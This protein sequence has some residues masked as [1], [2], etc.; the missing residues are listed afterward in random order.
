MGGTPQTPGRSVQTAE[1]CRPEDQMQKMQI[2]QIQ[3]SLPWLSGRCRWGPTITRKLEAIKKLLAPTNVNELCQFLCITGF[4]RKFVPFYAN[5]TN[6]LT[7]L[8]RKGTKFMWSEQCNNAFNILKEELSKL[9]S[10]QF[11]DPN[12]PFKLLT[13]TSNCSYSGILHQAQDEESA[14]LILIAYFSGSCN[15]T[16]QPWNITQ[17]NDVLC[18]GSINKFSFYLTGAEYTLYCD[19]K[20]L[21]PFLTTGLKNKTM[22]RWALQLQQY[23][24]KFQHVAGKD[25]HSRCDI[26]FENN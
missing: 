24:I 13:D 7:K 23:N 25:N 17:K 14:Q 10:L 3:S 9:L 21:T 16:Q 22:D 8:V 18:I 19:H 2:F 26:T 15:H 6:C 11:P 1:A 12:K 4:Y 5:I 20:P